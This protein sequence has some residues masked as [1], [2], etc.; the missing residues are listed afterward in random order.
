[1]ICE[2][3]NSSCWRT[4]IAILEHLLAG[5]PPEELLEIVDRGEIFRHQD[6]EGLLREILRVGVGDAAAAKIAG[7]PVR[8]VVDERGERGR[9][10][11]GHDV[12]S[13][14]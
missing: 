11:L 4:A 9:E 13:V 3:W 12:G 1:M 5:D 10:G 6:F 7:E 14:R 8:L 2:L